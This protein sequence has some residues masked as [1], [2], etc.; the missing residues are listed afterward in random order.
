YHLLLL[1]ETTEGY[2]NL[3]KLVTEAHLRGFHYKPRVD[4]ALLR[5]YRK[6]L[7]ATSACLSGEIPRAILEG[8]FQ[9]ARRLAEE[10][11]DLFGKGN[12]FLELQSHGLPEELKVNRHL[13]A[14]AKELDLP[15]VATNDVHYVNR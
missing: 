11:R 13:I 10:Y 9:D 3:M 2:K 5:R 14:L 1:A 15:L 4:K 6:G 12:F 8:R 7:I